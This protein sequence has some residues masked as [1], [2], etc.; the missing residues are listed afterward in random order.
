[1][2]RAPTCVVTALSI[3]VL[4]GAV[5]FGQTRPAPRASLDHVMDQIAAVR[6]FT[7]V[8]IAP[9]GKR[10][11]WVESLREKT[12]APS[13]VSAIS[14]LDLSSPSATARRIIGG[15]GTAARVEHDLAWSPDG[16][17][18]AF[19]SDREQPGQLQLYVVA[20]GEVSGRKVT[21]LTGSLAKPRWSPD[22]KVLALLFTENAP[23][24]PGP[25][26]PR[27]PE[28]GIVEERVYE[29][30]LITV[31]LA[32]GRVLRISPPNLYVY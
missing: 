17:R 5:G 19:L 24:T 3:L 13:P 26:E 28:T 10:V 25:L 7:E 21:N 16:H 27:T 15:K 14:V 1:M 4:S 8:A 29:Q 23:R 9:D 18:L 11:A 2:S 6:R 12:K 30:R 32:S 20:A 31:D 22:G